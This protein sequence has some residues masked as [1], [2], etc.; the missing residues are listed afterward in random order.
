MESYPAKDIAFN[1]GAMKFKISLTGLSKLQL[2]SLNY[3]ISKHNDFAQH[4]Y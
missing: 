3:D 4:A 2:V 1:T